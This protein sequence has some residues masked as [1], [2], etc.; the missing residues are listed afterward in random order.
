[1][2]PFYPCATMERCVVEGQVATAN[3]MA[4]MFSHLPSCGRPTRV[5]LYD[6]HTLQNRF[7]LSNHAVASLQTAVPLMLR[8]ITSA[9]VEG[10]AGDAGGADDAAPGNAERIDAI[11]FPDD[12]A[13]KRFRHMFE[14]ESLGFA[15]EIVVCGK[16]RLGDERVVTVLD[17]APEGKHVLMV[18]DLV[19]TGGTLFECGRALSERGAL[20]VSAFVV[21]PVFPNESWR[22][23]AR[24]GDRAVF[25]Q[26]FTTNSVPTVA[27]VL[28]KDDVFVV[29]DLAEQVVEDLL[30]G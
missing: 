21:H 15:F 19:Q 26:F 3:T 5:M 11:A 23:F 4:Q 10:G 12:G 7:Y 18:D 20:S 6:L 8:H 24:G 30:W 1:M 9:P 16:H 27:R 17:G 28:P 22:R 14:A 13:A 29:L 2:L 25:R